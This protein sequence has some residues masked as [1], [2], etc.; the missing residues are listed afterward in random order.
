MWNISELLRG[1]YKKEKYGDVILP[2]CLLRRFDCILYET[3]QEV[4]AKEENT[5]IDAILNRIT[6]VNF[7]NTS[8]YDFEKLLE[9]PDNIGSNLKN[10][11]QVLSGNVRDIIENFEFS[12]EIN[13][14]DGNNLL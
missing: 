1:T 11:I 5:K 14:M 3:K 8:Q 6:K 4:L 10:Y 2:L 7:N 9:D 13:K 12:K